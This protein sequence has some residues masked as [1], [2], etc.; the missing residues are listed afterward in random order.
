M[1]IA[2]KL[3]KTNNNNQK[4]EEEEQ[5]PEKDEEEEQQ[6]EEEDE[7]QQEEEKQQQ[8]KSRAESKVDDIQDEKT[9]QY[10]T[11]EYTMSEEKPIEEQLNTLRAEIEEL[12]YGENPELIDEMIQQR[13]MD[14]HLLLE[15]LLERE[16]KKFDGR[17]YQSNTS[18]QRDNDENINHIIFGRKGKIEKK[19]AMNIFV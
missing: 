14:I 16:K 13:G 11:N 19:K 17:K 5:Q 9:D 10:L 12:G 7:Q 3:N 15:Y 6:Q 8:E 18:D 1:Q 2:K 4:K